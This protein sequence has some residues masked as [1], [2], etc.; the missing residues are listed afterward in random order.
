MLQPGQQ[1]ENYRIDSVLGEGGMGTIY[2]ATDVNLMR[3][4]AVKVMHGNLADDPTFQGRFLQ[5][6][7]AAARLDHPS[8]VRIYHFGRES[9]LLYIVMEL[10]DGLSLGAYLRQLARLNQVVRLEE[11]V[12]LIA[13]AADA[14]G[15]AH[16]QGV[17]HRDIKPDNILVKRLDQPDRPGDPPLRAMVTDFGLARLMGM[18]QDTQSGLMMGTLPY[19]SPEQV[20]GLPVDGRSDIYSLGVVLYQLT[21]GRL[22]LEIRSPEQAVQAHQYEE[23]VA[24]RETHAGVPVAI[25]TIIMRALARRAENRYQTAE[26]LA[27]DLR[28]A[29]TTLG[30]QEALAF[31]EETDS[32]IVSMVTEFPTPAR[33]LEWDMR[34]RLLEGEGICRVLLQNHSLAPQSATLTLETPR[35]G[36]YADAAQKQVSLVPGQMGVVDFYLKPMKQPFIGRDRNWPFII[37]VTPHSSLGGPAPGMDGLVRAT[38]QM[39]WWLALLLAALLLVGCGLALWLLISLPMVNNLLFS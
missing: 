1:I 15:Y 13:Q 32:T 5:E 4:V 36:L 26:E 29:T 28:R 33:Q 20:L 6:A 38:P 31:T 35:G 22:P 23:V 16:R 24:P 10:I 11:T 39:P 7:R 14:L 3:P 30:N 37:R 25:E 17:I 27:A 18:E 8:I 21:T 9:G 19:M 34:P 2:R 12:S